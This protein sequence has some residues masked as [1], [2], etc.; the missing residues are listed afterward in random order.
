MDL[1]TATY[2]F[3][4][5]FHYAGLNDFPSVNS[6]SQNNR[7]NL[8]IFVTLCPRFL[9]LLNLLC[10]VYIAYME[11]FANKPSTIYLLIN[12]VIMLMVPFRLILGRTEKLINKVNAISTIALNNLS[13][14]IDFHLFKNKMVSHVYKIFIPICVSVSA[15]LIIKSRSHSVGMSFIIAFSLIAIG[16]LVLHGIFYVELVNCLLISLKN[17]LKSTGMTSSD[18]KIED[19]ILKRF[20]NRFID[21]KDRIEEFRHIKIIHFKIHELSVKINKY[22]GWNYLLVMFTEWMRFNATLYSV[23]VLVRGFG[24]NISALRKYQILLFVFYA[25]QKFVEFVCTE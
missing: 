14:E 15:F 6:S 13:L 24:P 22:F 16:I 23:F 19:K 18:S 12:A 17:H 25:F 1:H 4:A 2:P 21:H 20:N 10:L 7:K 11:N 5:L 9:L 3:L 8:N